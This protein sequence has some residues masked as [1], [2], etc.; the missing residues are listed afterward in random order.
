[1]ETFDESPC[2]LQ[3]TEDVNNSK[4]SPDIFMTSFTAIEIGNVLF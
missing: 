2:E 4:Y 3:T 1:M